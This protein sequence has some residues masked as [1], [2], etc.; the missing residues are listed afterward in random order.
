[1]C[2][3]NANLR[4]EG[5]LAQWGFPNNYTL[6]KHLAEYMVSVVWCGAV[7]RRFACSTSACQ[8]PLLASQNQCRQLRLLHCA[9]VATDQMHLQQPVCQLQ[10]GIWQVLNTCAL[11]VC[12]YV[13]AGGRLPKVLQPA[14]CHLPPHTHL[15]LCTGPVPR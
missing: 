15:L 14:C 13:P 12:V 3:H 6:S 9:C 1:M 5:M 8:V 4:A 2:A 11:F 7:S 10:T